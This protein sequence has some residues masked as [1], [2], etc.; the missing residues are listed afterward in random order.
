MSNLAETY[1]PF[2]TGPGA[3][4]TPDRWRRMSR[5]FRYNGV[6]PGYS[7]MF[8]ATIA[9]GVVTI[10]PGGIWVDGFYG[11]TTVAHTVS[12]VGLGAGLVVLRADPTARTIGF[13][14]LPGVQGTI[15]PTQS[16]TGIYEIPLYYVQTSTAML[17]VRQ[18]ATATNDNYRPVT[19]NGP[20][21]NSNYCARGRM[22]RVN[23]YTTSTAN[24]NYGFDT[25]DYGNAYFSSWQF[26]CPYSD[27]Y[28]VTAQVGF[29]CNAIGQWY[30]MRIVR[31]GAT[32]DWNGTTNSSVVGAYMSCQLTDIIPCKAG[33]TINIQ[34][35][36]STTGCQGLVGKDRAYFAVRSMSR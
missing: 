29:I 20:Y 16:L 2:D 28:L 21:N 25:V 4:A 30:N 19:P 15:L 32:M 8:S 24:N 31:N 6:V 22:Y 34:H 10:N 17:D 18:F 27:D 1:I 11:E 5:G 23:A 33:D 36:C 9:A 3:T 13:F 14:Y 12:S 35:N 26:V 7:N